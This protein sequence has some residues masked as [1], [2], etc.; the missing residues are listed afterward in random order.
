MSRLRPRP[1]TARHPHPGRPHASAACWALYGQLLVREYS[2]AVSRRVH[3]L[4]VSAYVAQHPATSPRQPIKHM[5]LHLIELCLLVDHSTPDH[6]ATKLLATILETPPDLRW[7][8][9]PAPNGTVTVSD[10][11]AARTRDAHRLIVERWARSVW[12]AWS[13][14]HATLRA[15]IERSLGSAHVPQ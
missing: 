13:P 7:L 12:N 14:H 4:T 2:L 1:A 5:S 3:R 10:V 8:E 9:P 11:L 15:W 6:Q